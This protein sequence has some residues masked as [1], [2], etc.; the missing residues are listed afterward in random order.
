MIRSNHLVIDLNKAI[1][2]RHYY[3]NQHGQTRRLKPNGPSAFGEVFN[4]EEFCRPVQGRKETYAETM[5]DAAKRKGIVDIWRPI[6]RVQF[7]NNHAVEFTDEK[8][9]S[10]WKKWN[11]KIFKKG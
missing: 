11:E 1:Y 6:T 10:I 9:Q 5:L 4:P 3:E 2:A 7:A 8:A